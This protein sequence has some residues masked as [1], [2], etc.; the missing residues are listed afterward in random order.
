MRKLKILFVLSMFCWSPVITAQTTNRQYVLVD[1]NVKQEIIEK[2]MSSLSTS[3]NEAKY[4]I[5]G[6]IDDAFNQYFTHKKTA[7]DVFEADSVESLHKLLKQKD[8][9]IRELQK[10]HFEEL[11]KENTKL[12]SE[13]FDSLADAS[14]ARYNELKYYWEVKYDS[15]VSFDS[16]IVSVLNDSI[17]S[18][19]HRLS[20]TIEKMDSL[21]AECAVL[22]QNALVF[23]GISEELSLRQRTLNE[24]YSSC[25]NSG[26]GYIEGDAVREKVDSYKELLG[27]LKQRIPAEQQKQ[28]DQIEKICKVVDFFDSAIAQLAMP[29][30]KEANDKLLEEYETL[31]ELCGML[32]PIQQTELAQVQQALDE[33]YL[34]VLH[35]RNGI[36]GTLKE[37]GLIP[38]EAAIDANLKMIDEKVGL[39]TSGKTNFDEGYYYRYYVHINKQLSDLRTWL[40]NFPKKDYGNSEVFVKH[41][42]EVSK[43]LVKE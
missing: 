13:R 19:S 6:L 32:Q 4:M 42:D 27:M 17:A 24:A 28:I 14:T 10:S 31:G 30:D 43:S 9:E 20:F 2:L 5:K 35:F 12:W 36:I 18:I 34:A 40:T 23:E 38:N 7:C 39:F 1:D 22:Q 37:E 26:L 25:L 15:V 21:Q 33:E 16:L 3:E 11:V 8:K 41:L 29:F